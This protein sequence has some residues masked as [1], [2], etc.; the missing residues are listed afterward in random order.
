[1]PDYNSLN[2]GYDFVNP[3]IPGSTNTPQP[4]TTP[5]QL[6]SYQINTTLANTPDPVIEG[7]KKSIFTVRPDEVKPTKGAILPAPDAPQMPTTR[8]K[9]KENETDTTAIV[10][11]G[12]S[13][14][15]ANNNKELS[16][17]YNY[18]QT[19]ALLGNT[20]S[21]AD[22]LANDLM[23][24]FDN[25]KNSR[26]LKN[27]YMI[28][29]NLS[30]SMSQLL[31]TKAA[32]L[33]EINSSITKATELDYKKEKDRLAAEGAANDDKYIM[34]LYSSFINNPANGVNGSP[35]TL[36]PTPIAN[37]VAS[38]ANLGG[39]IRSPLA[40]SNPPPAGQPVDVGYLNYLSRI[41]PQQNSMI[42][43]SDPNCK[44]CVVY[45]VQTGNK[46]FSAMNMA[47]GMTVPNVD[48]PSDRFIQ[49]LTIDLQNN[50]A[51]NAN[52]RLTYPL[53]V[54]NNDSNIAQN[55]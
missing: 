44:I 45:D 28:L 29:T 23:S 9:K 26:T 24:E 10:R 32:I 43:E 52:L 53:V 6:P 18:A 51:K 47:T 22:E 3:V 48:L 15:P 13:N 46:F 5:Q 7:P 34:D 49:D 39:I 11:A 16:T 41:T 50:V 12:D 30:Q 37:T 40:G 21:Q 17:M 36:A 20:L 42:M 25:I 4:V 38:S 19:T 35:A 33:R 55:Y 31:N 27:K 54:I 14:L 8:R 1:M 2:F